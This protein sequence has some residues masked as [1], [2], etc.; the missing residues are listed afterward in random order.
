MDTWGCTYTMAQQIEMIESLEGC[1]RFQ[2]GCPAAGSHPPPLCQMLCLLLSNCSLAANMRLP[3]LVLIDYVSAPDHTAT[4]GP[5][6]SADV[7]SLTHL[8][9]W[10]VLHAGPHRLAEPAE[11][12]LA[13]CGEEQRAGAAAAARQV[14]RLQSGS[15]QGGSCQGWA[16]MPI[17]LLF[18]YGMPPARTPCRPGLQV[19]F[20][21]GGG[22]G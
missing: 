22:G 15:L 12:L 16:F 3:S 6:T 13:D 2:V 14:G 5:P 1:T 7:T 4:P 21:A 8:C 17:C 10:S 18:Q 20:W 11:P 9:R 19:L